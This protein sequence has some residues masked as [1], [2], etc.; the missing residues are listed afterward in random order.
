MRNE[1]PLCQDIENTVRHRLAKTAHTNHSVARRETLIK[2][3][4]PKTGRVA[5]SSNRLDQWPVSARHEKWQTRFAGLQRTSATTMSAPAS[6]NAIHTHA[7]PS[8]EGRW[9]CLETSTAC[10][11][12]QHTWSSGAASAASALVAASSAAS[13]AGAQEHG[14]SAP[15]PAECA[16]SS[17]D[18][19]R[20]SCW[21]DFVSQ[22]QSTMPSRYLGAAARITSTFPTILMPKSRLRSRSGSDDLAS[23]LPAPRTLC[24]TVGSSRAMASGSRSRHCTSLRLLVL[25]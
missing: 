21:A 8:L 5:E 10:T 6:T 23:Q 3:R 12:E 7:P 11:H 18:R 15:A 20:D 22:L 17:C 25:M 14:A 1:T 16:W 19:G 24:A 9:Q 4:S 13:S 2:Q